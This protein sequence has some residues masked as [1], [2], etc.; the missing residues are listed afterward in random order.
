[1]AIFLFINNKF[2]ATWADVG[3]FFRADSSLNG[4]SSLGLVIGFKIG[5]GYITSSEFF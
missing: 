4:V 3:R 5:N 2:T 1:M